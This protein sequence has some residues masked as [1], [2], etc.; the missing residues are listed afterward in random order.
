MLELL[1][2]EKPIGR[3]PECSIVGRYASPFPIEHDLKTHSYP[4]VV[5]TF[6]KRVQLHTTG[7]DTLLQRRVMTCS[8]LPIAYNSVPG[9][10]EW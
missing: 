2:R 8:L 3:G 10:M 6:I 5:A 9:E 4:T 7:M 1:L